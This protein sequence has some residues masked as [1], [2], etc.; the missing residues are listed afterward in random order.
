MKFPLSLS[1]LPC[2]FL[3]SPWSNVNTKWLYMFSWSGGKDTCPCTVLCHCWPPLRL[4]DPPI[5]RYH[6]LSLL[7]LLLMSLMHLGIQLTGPH[8][9]HPFFQWW[10]SHI[11]FHTFPVDTISLQCFPWHAH[12]GCAKLSDMVLTQVGPQ[13]TSLNHWWLTTLIFQDTWHLA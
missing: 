7:H 13:G 2:S 9:T 1:P 5:T 6:L 10:S 4:A 12:P 11:Y 3:S 8:S